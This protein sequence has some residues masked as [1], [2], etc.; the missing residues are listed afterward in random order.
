MTPAQMIDLRTAAP[1]LVRGLAVLRHLDGADPLRADRVALELGLPRASAY[2]LLQ[3]L[4]QC[5]CVET[6]AAGR[7]R[8]ILGLR[9]VG[10]GG[11]GWEDLL[12]Q[13][14]AHLPGR[15]GLTV[16]WY[17]PT[18][19][20][21]ELVRQEHPRGESRVQAGPGFIRRWDGELDAVAVVGRAFLKGPPRLVGPLTRYGADGVLAELGV[22]EA[23]ALIARARREG[24]CSDCHFNSNGI[25]R[26]ALPFP[27]REDP[28]GVIA[29][30]EA[31]RFPNS[32]APETVLQEFRDA[33]QT[34]IE[35]KI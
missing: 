26:H 12:E 11:M 4:E 21:M 5:G 8:A 20:G 25:R 28:C 34:F 33:W 27:R 16:E 19:A 15:I 13:A 18:A 6:D 3:T 22:P 24:A 10:K 9:V 31:A 7:Y 29:L 35:P 2:R 14:M 23:R 32:P 30:A 17:L 1:A